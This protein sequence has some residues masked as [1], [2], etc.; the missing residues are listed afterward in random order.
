[1]VYSQKFSG[2]PANDAFGK[3][4]DGTDHSERLWLSLSK[5]FRRMDQ[6]KELYLFFQDLLRY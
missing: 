3:N 4:N 2:N 1:M 6:S 5:N